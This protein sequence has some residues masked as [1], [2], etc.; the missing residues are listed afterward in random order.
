MGAALELRKQA[1]ATQPKELQF[2]VNDLVVK[3]CGVA[4]TVFPNVNASY[5]DEGV[6][7]HPSVNIAIAVALESGLI[8]PI[9]TDCDKRSLGSLAREAKRVV[10]LARD[11]KLASSDLQGGTFTVSNLGMYG[12]VEFTSIINPPQAAILSVGAT[13]RI[14]AFVGDTDEVVAKQIMRLTLAADHRVTDG[15]EVARLLGEIKRLLEHP[16]ALLVG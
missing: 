5:S 7:Q 9:V 2:S 14:P 1:N 4:L 16:L 15:A 12:I 10:G 13:Q 11:N 8:T 3:A 6:I